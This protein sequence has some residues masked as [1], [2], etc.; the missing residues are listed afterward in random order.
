MIAGSSP[1]SSRVDC[2]TY[3]STDNMSNME[4]R[5]RLQSSSVV[6]ALHE[7]EAGALSDL[8]QRL[9]CGVG[10]DSVDVD[11][12]Q[13]G[14]ASPSSAVLSSSSLL[15]GENNGVSSVGNHE[16]EEEEEEKE[17]G[18]GVED[19]EVDEAVDKV[20]VLIEQGQETQEQIIQGV[21][22]QVRG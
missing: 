20:F 16:E 17:G 7:R 14:R 12:D 1:P 19:G 2:D 4:S 3:N 22:E 10:G 21:A 5:S 11:H 8:E 15:C 18:V 13:G 9:S 6:S